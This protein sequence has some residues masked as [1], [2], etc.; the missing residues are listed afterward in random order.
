LRFPQFQSRNVTQASLGKFDRLPR[1]P[2]GSTALVFDGCGL[3]D[4]S[5]A[6]PR[7]VHIGVCGRRV[8]RHADPA[9]PACSGV[10]FRSVPRFA[11]GFFP[12]GLTAP[13]LASL[14]GIAACSCL[15]LAVATNTP[16]EGLSPPIQCPCQ[17]HLRPPGVAAPAA[18][19]RWV[20][21]IGMT[22]RSYHVLKGKL[23]G[24]RCLIVIVGVDGPTASRARIGAVTRP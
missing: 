15:W 23:P 10:H 5:P 3:R 18:V 19:S 17:A 1:T 8:R 7:R 6:R 24:G 13:G 4:Q 20:S 22:E 21:G 2:A 12:H 16:R 14:D 9:G 11:S